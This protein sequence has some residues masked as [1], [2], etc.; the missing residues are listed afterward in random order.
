MTVQVE[1]PKSRD[2]RA[3]GNGTPMSRAERYEFA[4]L[5]RKFICEHF[6]SEDRKRCPEVSISITSFAADEHGSGQE[7]Y[8]DQ[9]TG[10]VIHH[11]EE[12]AGEI[13][14]WREEANHD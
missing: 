8:V 6:S 13:P 4:R 1:K 7:E 11:D 2:R 14:P 12:I 5:L 9:V 10:L 3:A